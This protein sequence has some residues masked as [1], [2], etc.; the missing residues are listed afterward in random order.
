MIREILPHLKICFNNRE[1]ASRPLRLTSVPQQKHCLAQP[2]EIILE[3]INYTG[4]IYT[5]IL[6][7]RA[8]LLIQTERRRWRDAD[9][10][11]KKEMMFL[12][13]V[14]GISGE[15]GVGVKSAAIWKNNP[16]VS[17]DREES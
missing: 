13:S 1:Q 3:A 5:N 9:R 10:K 6:I 4:S 11:V 12:K 2:H 17:A 7:S 14:R 15:K 8:G 16:D